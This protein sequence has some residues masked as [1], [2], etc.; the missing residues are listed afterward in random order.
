[1]FPFEGRGKKGELLER[2]IF[3]SR[4]NASSISCG[5][6]SFHKLI[7]VKQGLVSCHFS[8]IQKLLVKGNQ[9]LWY[10]KGIEQCVKAAFTGK[11]AAYSNTLVQL[12]SFFIPTR[13]NIHFGSNKC[14]CSYYYK[15]NFKFCNNCLQL[16]PTTTT[17]SLLTFLLWGQPHD[18][19]DHCQTVNSLI[20][21]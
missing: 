2:N 9:Q 20:L 6:K 19:S 16:Q 21:G 18:P 10:I 4:G 5:E 8:F 12:L 14:N 13:C 1:M 17:T 11:L 7:C 15:F 3:Y